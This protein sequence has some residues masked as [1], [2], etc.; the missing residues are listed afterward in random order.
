MLSNLL[1]YATK[2][3]GVHRLKGIVSWVQNAVRQFVWYLLEML[4]SER[5]EAIVR[6]E[7]AFDASGLSVIWQGMPSSYALMDKC[8]KHL[9]TKPFLK[10]DII[11]LPQN[12]GLIE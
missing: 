5:K 9:S 8:W 12:R 1:L 4:M 3:A 6:E 7:L 11:E 10:R 2:G